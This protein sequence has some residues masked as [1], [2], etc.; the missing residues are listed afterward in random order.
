[1]EQV[2]E[3]RPMGDPASALPFIGQILGALRAEVGSAA[4]VL[5]FVGAP[6]TLAAYAMEGKSTK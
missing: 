5:G 2:R 6:W 4:T 3:L 1:M